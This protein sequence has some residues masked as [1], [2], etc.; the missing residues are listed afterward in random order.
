MKNKKEVLAYAKKELRCM[1]PAA[2][3]LEHLW[4]A[5]LILSS[6][7]IVGIGIQM[8]FGCWLFWVAI[9]RLAISPIGTILKRYI[10][11]TAQT[12]LKG[13]ERIVGGEE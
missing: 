1:L 6:I 4:L 12:V 10:G 11:K 8:G 13:I 2:I 3:V 7:L 9:A 5:R